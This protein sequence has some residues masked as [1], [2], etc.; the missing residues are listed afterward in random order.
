MTTKSSISQLRQKTVQ[1]SEGERM[2]PWR[3]PFLTRKDEAGLIL[4]DGDDQSQKHCWKFS[5]SM[6]VKQLIEIDLIKSF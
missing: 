5:F 3:T 4:V 1:K 6:F 2:A